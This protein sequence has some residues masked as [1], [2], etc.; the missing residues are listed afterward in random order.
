ME[1][2]SEE[3]TINSERK[4]SLVHIQEN[5]KDPLPFESFSIC[6]SLRVWIVSER[7]N[8][9]EGPAVFK[10][11]ERSF[12]IYISF[13]WDACFDLMLWACVSNDLPVMYAFCKAF[14]TVDSPKDI[15]FLGQVNLPEI[16][17]TGD[18]LWHE[19]LVPAPLTN[20]HTYNLPLKP[21]FLA[22]HLEQPPL[23]FLSLPL[24]AFLSLFDS[25][26][27]TF[28]FLGK[29]LLKIKESLI[30]AFLEGIL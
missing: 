4:S 7:P 24:F 21:L 16:W 5:S 8:S 30:F 9:K 29:E 6:W 23:L 28:L 11:T 22:L 13:A 25:L 2:Y 10:I 20:H 17:W 15:L 12:F 18:L 1:G 26:F 19:L 14:C 27:F 3:L